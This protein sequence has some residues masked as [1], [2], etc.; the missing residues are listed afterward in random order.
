MNRE[1]DNI[2]RSGNEK[3]KN[4]PNQQPEKI[5][6]SGCLISL[7]KV[8]LLPPLILLFH[9]GGSS[10]QIQLGILLYHASWPSTSGNTACTAA[11]PTSIMLSSGSLVVKFWNHI[12]GAVST[13]VSALS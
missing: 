5:K 3:G 1:N 4:Q 8:I 6:K 11:M 7:L 12:P 10:L 13:R 9:K 2:Y